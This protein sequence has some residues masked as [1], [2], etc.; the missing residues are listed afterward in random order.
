MMWGIGERPLLAIVGR[1]DMLYK[2]IMTAFNAAAC[3]YA[4]VQYFG[5]E[6]EVIKDDD[7]HDDHRF[8]A[9]AVGSSESY[10]TSENRRKNNIPIWLI[11]TGPYVYFAVSYILVMFCMPGNGGHKK[12]TI[13]TNI[14]FSIHRFGEWTMLMLGESILSLLIVDIQEEWEYYKT[15][16]A[17]ILSVVL[18]QYLHFKSQ[19]H[20][21]D[22]HAMRRSKNGAFLFNVMN[23][24]YSAALVVM[25]VSYK[26][27][28]YEY[29]YSGESDS[30]RSLHHLDGRHLA[31]G[32][33]TQFDTEDRRQRIANLFTGALCVAWVSSDIMLL[34]HK[35]IKGNMNRFS[36]ESKILGGL[37]VLV[38]L[39]RLGLI[40]FVA[41]LSQYQTDP[42]LVAEAGLSAIVGQ[43]LLRVIGES[44]FPKEKIHHDTSAGHGDE[45]NQ[46]DDEKWPNTTEARAIPAKED[47]SMVVD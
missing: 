24:F 9:E 17:G 32:G 38:V 36:C 22:E 41:T 23:Q 39:A 5:A 40:I 3:I 7:H 30:H 45:E 13:P 28:L 6:G 1:R 25:G 20:H 15:F 26:M 33:A 8:L 19:P 2:S 43:V 46:F 10:Y 44:I 18:M 27:F 16:F 35:G 34:A 11:I 37:R 4:G 29:T 12:I 42:V 31:G 14:E 47:H 21:P